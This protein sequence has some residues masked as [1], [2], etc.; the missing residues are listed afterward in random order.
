MSFQLLRAI[1]QMLTASCSSSL[2]MARMTMFILMMARSA[3]RTSHPCSKETSARVLWGSRRS[4]Y[5]RCRQTKSKTHLNPS[6]YDIVWQM[7][8]PMS[9]GVSWRQ[10]RW[11]SDCL[12][13]CGQRDKGERGDGGRQ[14]CI[15][16]PCWSWLH[17][18][19]LCGWRWAIEDEAN[20][21]LFMP[22]F[23]RNLI[24]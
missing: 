7:T 8:F 9:L 5:Y 4:L 14:C 21:L 20:H 12:W 13:C 19:L 10:A 3:F 17:H 15:H 24:Q 1:I 2:A 6:A 22:R 18:V 23:T 16:P 11:P